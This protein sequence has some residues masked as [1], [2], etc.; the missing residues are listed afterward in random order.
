MTSS[1]KH[2][3]HQANPSDAMS[4]N[5]GLSYK[6]SVK[7]SLSDELINTY[8]LRPVAH[9]MVRLL[10]PTGVTPNQV[11]GA[12]I[13][14]GFIAAAVY[15]FGGPALLPLAGLLVT[16]KDLLDSADG[17]LARARRMYSRFGRFLDSVGDFVVNALV[18]AAIA[19]ALF[20]QTG[21]SPV[22]LAG[23]CGFF[24]ISLRVSY[25]VFYQT[26][27]L[28][29]RH[30]Y[31]VNRTTEEIQQAD[32][33]GDRRTLLMQKLF[34][35]LYGWQ[36]RLVSRLDGWSMRGILQEKLGAWYSDRTA[37]LLS[38]FLGLGTELFI[39]MLFS[40]A[41]RLDAYLWMNIVGMNAVWCFC[42]L[43]RRRVLRR[44]LIR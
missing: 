16:L 12:S 22:F 26:S 43:Y 2:G 15:A 8:L 37:L 41:R 27:Y 29:L 14:A 6:S 24:G 18:F 44:R 36:D 20:L 34:L 25:H 1:L 9:Q 39:L 21:W 35:L 4:S 3:D 32:L 23:L 17:Q 40:V 7:S 33:D 31:E 30:E 19:T 42:I 28:H 5:N 10:Y 13:G 11:T 38:G